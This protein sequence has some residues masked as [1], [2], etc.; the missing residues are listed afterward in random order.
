MSD[1][2][3]NVNVNDVTINDRDVVNVRSAEEVIKAM[4]KQIG[5][6]ESLLIPSLCKDLQNGWVKYDWQLFEL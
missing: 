2:L 4:A 5:K 1:D 6:G 3:Q